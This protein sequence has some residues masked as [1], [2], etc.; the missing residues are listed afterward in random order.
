M[1]RAY[2]LMVHE[3]RFCTPEQAIRKMTGLPAEKLRL[4][5]K[6]LLRDGYDADV[7][8]LDL[9][10]FC[11]TATYAHGSGRCAGIRAVFCGGKKID[12]EGKR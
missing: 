11:D 8:L 6:G 7:L 10:E 9:D 4:A 3:R 12:P 2:R 1:A 5:G